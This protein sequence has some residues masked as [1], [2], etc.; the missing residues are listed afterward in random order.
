MNGADPGE[1]LEIMWHEL[2]EPDARIDGDAFTWDSGGGAG[3]NPRLEKFQHLDQHGIVN[4]VA[5]HRPRLT[6]HMH[7][8]DRCLVAGDDGEAL[9]IVGQRRDV[10]DNVRTDSECRLH[11]GAV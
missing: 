9:R 6:A 2:A 5:L 11:Y 3:L 1:E 4:R 7:Q 8:H 10:V